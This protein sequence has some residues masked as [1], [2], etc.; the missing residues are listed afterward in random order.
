MRIVIAGGTGLIGRK[1][2]EVLLEEGH[3]VVILTRQKVHS[4][5][6]GV[7]YVQWL[8]AGA[9]PERE[10]ESADGF[11][12]LAGVSLNDGRWTAK[13]REQIYESRMKAT[14][15]ILRIMAALPVKPAVLVNASAIGIYPASTEAM[16]MEDA[17]KLAEDFLGRT[18]LDWERRASAA[19]T[20][21]VRTVYTR[22]GVVLDKRSG[23]L[24]LMS[25][26]YRLF[27][28]GTVGSGR[29]WVSWVH[30]TDAARAVAFALKNDA[31]RGPVNVTAPVPKRM[32]EFGRTIASVLNRPH[33]FPVPA[34]A[35]KLILGAK[36]S[37][38]LE[39]Q[40][41]MPEALAK[42]GFAFQYPELE[43]ALK[44]LLA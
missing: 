35:M 31:L 6:S 12:N 41:V 24:P 38:V 37:L 29:Q 34:F 20:L 22:F 43:A 3:E 25:L 32:K 5:R 18:V 7:T 10:M 21:G 23:A 14:D 30:V 11:V 1:V 44:D 8:E 15:E 9:Q 40:H 27:A 26:P 16:Y 33:W 39:G 28:G 17:S 42:N 19:E 4:D 2:T 13:H 36:S